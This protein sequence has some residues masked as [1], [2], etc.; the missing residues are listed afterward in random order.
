MILGTPSASRVFVAAAA[1]DTAQ[2]KALITES[3][4]L[5]TSHPIARPNDFTNSDYHKPLKSRN[6][7]IPMNR[8]PV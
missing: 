8:I 2:T 7:R 4:R 3:K 6:W 1:S 5:K